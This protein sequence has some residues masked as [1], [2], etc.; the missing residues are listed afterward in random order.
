M[1]TIY[2]LFN[3]FNYTALFWFIASVQ[4]Y[5]QYNNLL[6]VTFCDAFFLS[7]RIDSSLDTEII[8]KLQS[9]TFEGGT[10][11]YVMVFIILYFAIAIPVNYFGKDK[12]KSDGYVLK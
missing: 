3:D 7:P 11:A 8:T 4:I 5:L 1:I 9:N 10:V 12:S 2:I 6:F